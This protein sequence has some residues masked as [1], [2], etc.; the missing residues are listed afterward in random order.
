MSQYLFI[1]L[2]LINYNQKHPKNFNKYF[3]LRVILIK[4]FLTIFISQ[5]HTMKIF[6]YIIYSQAKNISTFKRK[7]PLYINMLSDS[8]SDITY[9]LLSQVEKYDEN[10]FGYSRYW[11]EEIQEILQN[12]T[13]SNLPLI[14]QDF[15]QKNFTKK[16]FNGSNEND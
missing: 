4:S 6:W 9:Q 2:I 12:Y 8:I 5:K 10:P 7:Y 14:V 16:I 11:R 3:N 1:H 15:I 13:N